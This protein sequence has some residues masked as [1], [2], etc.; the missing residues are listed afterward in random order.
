MGILEEAIEKSL[1][2]FTPGEFTEELKKTREILKE[3]NRNLRELNRNLERI[4]TR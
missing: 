1:K 2:D 3:L 4:L